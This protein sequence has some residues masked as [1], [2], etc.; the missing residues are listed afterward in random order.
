LGA[1]KFNVEVIAWLV[2]R[3]P[4]PVNPAAPVPHSAKRRTH[5][6][7]F[8]VFALFSVSIFFLLSSTFRFN[9]MYCISTTHHN[10]TQESIYIYITAKLFSFANTVAATLKV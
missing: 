4:Q 10:I 2:N 7:A 6:F 1:E 9:I 3:Q 8:F 5:L